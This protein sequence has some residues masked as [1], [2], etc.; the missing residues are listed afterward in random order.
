MQIKNKSESKVIIVACICTVIIVLGFSLM[1]GSIK[2]K[3]SEYVEVKSEIK[4]IELTKDDYELIR[5]DEKDNENIFIVLE[6]RNLTPKELAYLVNE[7]GKK[8]SRKFKVYLF[9]DKEKS[10]DFEYRI[11]QIQTVAKPIDSNKIEIRKYYKVDKEVKDKPKHYTIKDIK[12]KDG[13]TF[14]EINLNSITN[15]EK[16]IGQIKFLGDNIRS[17]NHNKDLGTLYINAYF[18]EKASLS[19]NYTSENK[20]LIIHNQIIDA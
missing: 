15:P 11:D 13:N 2:S 1:Q 14:I 8:S 18:D 4:N 20:N 17:L 10:N 5:I 16:A 19:W 12:E 7:L 9:T 3:K 6:K